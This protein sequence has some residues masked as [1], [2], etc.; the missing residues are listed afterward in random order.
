MP[1]GSLPRSDAVGSL[2]A[3]ASR[4]PAAGWHGATGRQHNRPAQ[5]PLPQRGPAPLPSSPRIQG[6]R[7]GG[8]GGP[9]PLPL[10]VRALPVARPSP[11]A[12]ERRPSGEAAL[13]NEGPGVARVRAGLSPAP[14]EAAMRPCPSPARERGSRRQAG[15]GPAREPS[16]TRRTHLSAAKAAGPRPAPA[17]PPLPLTP[18]SSPPYRGHPA[19]GSRLPATAGPP[20]RP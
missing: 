14:R 1:R 16:S 11:L 7:A 5:A 10:L 19:G 13:P 17:P 12:P 20:P 2:G 6:R 4:R 9:G 3:T 18:P 15:R 8:R